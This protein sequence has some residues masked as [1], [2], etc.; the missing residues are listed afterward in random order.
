MGGNSCSNM[1]LIFKRKK[2][3]NGDLCVSAIMI[4]FSAS[5][6]VTDSNTHP[7]NS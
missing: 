7:L 4:I 1:K 6:T 2:N 3:R 5:A